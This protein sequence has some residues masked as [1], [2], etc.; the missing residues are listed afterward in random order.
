MPK[1]SLEQVM[2]LLEEDMDNGLS[3][4]PKARENSPI[5]MLPTYV[6]RMPD[7]SESGDFLA[8]D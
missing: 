3:A 8:L 4:D 5:K 7:G 6:R 1:S 2:K